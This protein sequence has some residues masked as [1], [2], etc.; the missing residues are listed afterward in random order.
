[1]AAEAGENDLSVLVQ[2]RH[3]LRTKLYVPSI[4]PGQISRLRLFDLLNSGLDKAL[5]LVSAPPGYGKTTL[6]SSWLAETNLPSAW[7]S[8]DDGDN[9]PIRFLNYLLTTLL[10]LAPG[11]EGELFGILQGGQPARCE[12]VARGLVNELA[13]SS[14]PLVLVLDDFHVIRSHSVLD[15]LS[16]L[17][18]HIPPQLHLLI[19]TRMDPPLPL[20]RLRVRNQLVEI[21]LDQLRF[22]P[23]EIALFLNDV[24]GLTLTPGALFALEARTE[25]WIAGLQLAAL[26][27]QASRDVHA[28]I[29]AFT[30]SHRYVMDYLIEEVL[31]HQSPQVASFLMQTSFLDRLCGPLCEAVVETQ[32]AEPVDGQSIL[33]ALEGDN[34]FVIPLDHERHWYRYHHLFSDVLR[35]HLETQFSNL[36]PELHHRASQWYKQN[37]FVSESIQQA[38]LAGEGDRAAQLI[39]QNGCFLLISGEVATFLDWTDAIEFQ[40]EAHPWLAIQK[41]WALALTGNLAEV[42]PTLEA[43][44]KLLA[45]LEP[46]LEVKTML[47]TIAAAR[48]YSANLQGDTRATMQHAQKALTLLPDCSSISRSVRSVVTSVLGGSSWSNGNLEEASRAYAEAIRIG[49]AAGNAHMVVITQTN[50]AEILV[51]Q[52]RLGRAADLFNQSL[53]MAVRP[54]GQKSPLAGSIFAGLGKLSYERD[55]LDDAE[56]C[57]RQC[58]DLSRRWGDAGLQALAWAML[59]RLEHARENPEGALDEVRSAQRLADDQPLSLQRSLQVNYEL[60]RLWLAQGDLE[61][62]S[63]LVRSSGVSFDDEIPYHR[64]LEYFILLRVLLARGEYAAALALSKRLVLQTEQAGARGS[65]I[66]ILSLQALAC[67][68]GKDTEGSLAALGKALSLA[69]TEGYVRTFLDEGEPMTRLLCQVKSR[70]GGGGYA[71]GLLSRIG[72]TPGMTPPSMRLLIEPLT[73]RELEVLRL[74][75]AGCSNQA[76]S[77]QLVISP[78]TVKRH[79]SNIYA[80]LGVKTRTQAVAIGKELKIFE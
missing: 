76:I 49:R 42:E 35:K 10:P 31:K 53:P 36:L 73:E 59:A 19:L 45:S 43:P 1:M 52:G 58:I 28:F 8:L 25:G 9:D 12:E 57:F 47:G 33:E 15:L 66:E 7:L 48:A 13:L 54:D 34:L 69:R 75:E 51:E 14:A 63:Q 41:G 50:L 23:D 72:K 62:A 3:L 61:R 40:S 68:G 6:V 20:A 79:I 21:R 17:L 27:M 65:A 38:I 11:I 2:D 29:S 77:G 67:Q 74:I 80:K 78:A 16:L 32:T 39:E 70:K 4:R 30:G 46:T 71:E 64:D 26:S 18:E 5:I 56:Q 37:G 24:M 22:T 55:R 44:E 60:A